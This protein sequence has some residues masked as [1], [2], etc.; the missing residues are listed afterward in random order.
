MCFFVTLK[1]PYSEQDS[2]KVGY[3]AC[4]RCKKDSFLQ[5]E[6]A[7]LTDPSSRILTRKNREVQRALFKNTDPEVFH[8]KVAQTEKSK[9][10]NC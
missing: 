1:F 9:L 5:L 10:S 6:N 2:D 8:V 4:L 3:A 7:F